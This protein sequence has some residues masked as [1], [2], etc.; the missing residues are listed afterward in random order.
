MIDLANCTLANFKSAF[1]SDYQGLLVE[2]KPKTKAKLSQL[3][4]AQSKPSTTIAGS[5]RGL[6][7]LVAEQTQCHISSTCQKESEINPPIRPSKPPDL[8]SSSTQS[9]SSNTYRFFNECQHLERCKYSGTRQADRIK[10]QL[11]NQLLLTGSLDDQVIRDAEEQR[12]KLKWKLSSSNHPE[13]LAA[14]KN[15][16]GKT[17]DGAKFTIG[18]FVE[19]KCPKYPVRKP[20]EYLRRTID[21]TCVYDLTGLGIE[22]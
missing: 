12:G 5:N 17:T 8:K 6:A 18:E 15:K 10:E 11:K 7:S 16:R 19:E 21:L 14:V 13:T 9:T 20:R 1:N 2:Q 3:K 22:D 4:A